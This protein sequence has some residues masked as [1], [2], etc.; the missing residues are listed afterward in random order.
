[1]TH[2]LVSGINFSPSPA[3]VFNRLNMDENHPLAG[4]AQ[5]LLEQALSIAAP[6]ALYKPA[7][8]ES[9]EEDCVMIDG[10]TFKSRVLRVN[11]EKVH[12]VFAYVATCGNELREWALSFDDMMYQYWADAINEMALGVAIRAMNKDI[13]KRYRPGKTSSMSPGSLKEWPVQQQ[14]P[15]FKILGDVENTVGVKLTESMLMIP[16]KSVSGIIFPSEE[17]FESCLLCP[18]SD[19]PGRRA[20]YDPHL[21]EKKYNQNI[22]GVRRLK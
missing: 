15:L 2:H 6:V 18:R 9:V 3:Q 19:C 22:F 17:N 16:N 11:L 7:Y 21:F 14:K 20:P 4:E 12:R 1:M 5:H 8:I 10:A 13:Q